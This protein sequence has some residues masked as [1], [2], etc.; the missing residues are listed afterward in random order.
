MGAVCRT[1]FIT[2]GR[3]RDKERR[4]SSSQE[5]EGRREKLREEREKSRTRT[6]SGLSLHVDLV[7]DLC[8]VLSLIHYYSGFTYINTYL[9]IRSWWHL[10]TNPRLQ[11]EDISH[12]FCEFWCI[13]QSSQQ[14]RTNQKIKN[15]PKNSRIVLSTLLQPPVC[16]SIDPLPYF[17]E[18]SQSLP[19][20]DV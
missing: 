5:K 8:T 11:K 13:S 4:N 7:I 14:V 9:R 10:E 6:G 2:F 20:F 18:D 15:A 19:M 17:S 16:S 1:S 12:Y 3:E